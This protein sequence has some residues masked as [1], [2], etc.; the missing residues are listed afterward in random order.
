MSIQVLQ[1]PSDIQAAQSPIVFSVTTSGSSQAY[2]ASEFQYTANLYIWSGIPSQSGSYLYQ[3]RK[4]PNPSGSG[5]F[6]FSKMINSTLT[7]LAAESGD[8][9]N[10]IKYYKADFGFQYASGSSYVTQSGGL[11][12]VTC[13]VGGTLFKAYD[14]YGVFPDRINDSLY[15]QTR[16]TSWPVLS[17]TPTVTQSV[18]LT[19]RGW[20]G[21]FAD[22]QRGIPIWIGPNNTSLPSSLAMTASYTD[23]TRTSGSLGLSAVTGSPSSSRQIYIGSEVYP[24]DASFYAL[25][26]V[27]TTKTLDKYV[28][29][30]YSGSVVMTSLNYEVVCPHYYEPIRIAYK[31]KYGQFDF[32]NFYKRHDNTFNTDQRVYQP[33]LGTWNS[34]TLSYNQFQTAQQRYIVD[35][36]EVLSVNSDWVEEGYNNLFKQLMVSDEI[37]W[38]VGPYVN[39]SG[40]V[41]SLGTEV[42]PLTIQTNS[43]LFKTGVNNKL[44]QYTF[45]FDI[46]QP[47][48]LLL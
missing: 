47:Y 32:F 25:W 24:G 8:G 18:T 17:D 16:F 31:N 38:V 33:Q 15:Q 12:P 14:G 44:I 42:K 6:D 40:V 4:Y 35:A 34:S 13:S 1:K 29:N 43:L 23:G 48:K 10:N 2:T 19:D 28:F 20:L 26:N 37:Y 46:G 39:P 45:T 41:S 5:I 7:R 22:N 36:T 9:E 30:V 11:T 27:S 21:N 3:A